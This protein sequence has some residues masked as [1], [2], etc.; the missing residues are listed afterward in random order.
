[1]SATAQAQ[2]VDSRSMASAP[3]VARVAGPGAKITAPVDIEIV[4]QPDPRAGMRRVRIVARPSVDAASLAIEVSADSGL[5]LAPGTAATWTGAARAG[6]EVVRD[7]D[8]V[9]SGPGEMRL[10]VTATVK[11]GDDFTQTG[12]HEFALN[13]SAAVRSLGASKSFR[14]RVTDPGSRNVLEVPARTP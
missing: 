13:P 9:V 10:L 3:S 1:M 12:L 5:A 2:T 8:L 4:P 6:D 7:L 11:F 14:A